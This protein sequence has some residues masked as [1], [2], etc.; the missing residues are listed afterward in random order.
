VGFVVNAPRPLK[1][2]IDGLEVF[3][4]PLSSGEHL[5]LAAASDKYKDEDRFR[6]FVL[7]NLVRYLERWNLEIKH[8]DG[9]TEPLPI[10]VE[11]MSRVPA[12]VLLEIWRA[13][14]RSAWEVPEDSPLD[15]G[16]DSGDSSL[17]ELL[18]M[19]QSSASQ[20]S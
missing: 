15:R 11:A 16:S 17:E 5:S 14:Q 12:G 13:L 8:P 6:E 10:T 1:T 19:A 7:P 3:A 9:A 2:K 20:Q 18:T 4:A